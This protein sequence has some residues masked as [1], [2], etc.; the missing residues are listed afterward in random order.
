VCASVFGVSPALV[1]ARLPPAPD[2]ARGA[3]DRE[4]EAPVCAGQ[5]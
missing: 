5:I 4:A 3:G 1:T 2:R